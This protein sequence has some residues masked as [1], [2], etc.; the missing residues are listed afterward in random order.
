[1]PKLERFNSD[2]KAAVECNDTNFIQSD[3]TVKLSRN[4]MRGITASSPTKNKVNLQVGALH[5]SRARRQGEVVFMK[6]KWIR[7]TCRHWTKTVIGP[8]S[9][10]MPIQAY[11]CTLL[12]VTSRLEAP[13]LH[14]GCKPNYWGC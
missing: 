4:V 8:I 3:V 11:R 12:I 1:L 14:T 10:M 6:V 9:R 2:L 7:P 13:A 5:A